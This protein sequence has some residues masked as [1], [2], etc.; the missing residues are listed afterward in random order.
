KEISLHYK[1]LYHKEMSEALSCLFCKLQHN[2]PNIL[3][4]ND[5]CYLILD[6]FPLAIQHMLLIPKK[7]A[8]YLHEYSSDELNDILPTIQHVVKTLGIKK[9]NLLQNNGHL[10]SIEHVHFHI[11]PCL[12]QGLN[13]QW[14]VIKTESD[15]VEKTVNELKKRLS[16][17]K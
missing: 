13:I 17:R 7:H 6:I 15:Y 11:I 2:N 4:Q 16:E 3:Y 12:E 1:S 9:Y 5:S 10:Q 8:P 14:N